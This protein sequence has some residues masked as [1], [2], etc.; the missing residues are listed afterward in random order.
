MAATIPA[1][2]ILSALQWRYATKLFDPAKKIAPELW[3]TLEKSLILA[4]SSCGLQPWKFIVVTDPD[5]KARL[6]VK[7]HHQPQ[8]TDCSH[9]LIVAHRTTMTP[10]DVHR[11]IFATAVAHGKP[12][13]ELDRYKNMMLGL[14]ASPGFDASAW[15]ARQSYIALG[16]VL[17]TAALLGVDAC[18]MEGID[19]AGFD[20]L[21][22]LPP[23]GY[24]AQMSAAFGYRSPADSRAT[25]KKVRYDASELITHI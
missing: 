15:A 9:Y 19:P 6:R 23:T 14:I 20:E 24:T 16:F 5:M 2:T 1:E 4:P 21:L 25:E 7:A 22:N 17:Q 11:L 8:V 13:S 3:S 10:T 18:P 12:E